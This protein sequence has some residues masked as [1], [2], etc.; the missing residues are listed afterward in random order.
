MI[1]LILLLIF[2]IGYS[3]IFGVII[4]SIS[5]SII[6]KELL[7]KNNILAGVSNYDNTILKKGE[8]FID[9]RTMSIKVGDGITTC[10]YLNSV[11]GSCAPVYGIKEINDRDID[12]PNMVAKISTGN[13]LNI[14]LY[15]IKECIVLLS[16]N[17]ND[18]NKTITSEDCYCPENNNIRELKY[19]DISITKINNKVVINGRITGLYDKQI[20]S[21]VFQNLP[22]AKEFS[23]GTLSSPRCHGTTY[24]EAGSGNLMININRKMLNVELDINIEYYI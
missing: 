8:V 21:I 23:V 15:A 10:K 20:S 14:I 22:V 11:V 12:I 2:M 19:T 3:L 13:T 16:R 4:V 5:K 18:I 9:T 6:N 1:N 24:I 7:L 17:Q